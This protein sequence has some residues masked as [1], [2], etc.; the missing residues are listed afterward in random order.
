MAPRSNHRS[1]ELLQ[2]QGHPLKGSRQEKTES[3][4]ENYVFFLRAQ[5]SRSCTGFI[6]AFDSCL[7]LH[8]LF[9]VGGVILKTAP[10]THEDQEHE[11]LQLWKQLD[12]NILI[13]IEFHAPYSLSRTQKISGSMP[14]PIV[15]FRSNGCKPTLAGLRHGQ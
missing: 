1:P 11:H 5:T 4:Q 9:Q 2:I 15:V 8:P 10:V 12:N 7:F 14:Y 3:I 6:R 13:N